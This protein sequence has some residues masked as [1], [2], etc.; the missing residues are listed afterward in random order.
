MMNI[1]G[2]KVNTG[3]NHG[4]SPMPMNGDKKVVLKEDKTAISAEA[5]KSLQP[6]Y[7][8]YFQTERFNELKPYIVINNNFNIEYGNDISKSR[9]Y[10]SIKILNEIFN[11]F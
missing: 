3:H 7:K 5:K 2:G 11:Y 4:D 1:E 6:L 9:R 10:F 8:D